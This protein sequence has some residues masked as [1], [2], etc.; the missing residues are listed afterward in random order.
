MSQAIQP[1]AAAPAPPAASNA[2][3]QS[4]LNHLMR[5]YRSDLSNN[6]EATV[7]ASLGRQITATAKA[8]GTSVTLPKAAGG[9]SAARGQRRRQGQCD[10]LI[11]G[12]DWPRL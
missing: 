9:G 11:R 7:L 2:R 6:A 4:Q 12:G 5:Q 10:G 8:L 1:A 3:D